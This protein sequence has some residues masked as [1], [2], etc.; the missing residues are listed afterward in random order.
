MPE[1]IVF[2]I[3]DKKECFLDQKIEVSKTS[4]NSK[5]FN[6]NFFPWFCQKSS[7]LPCVNVKQIMQQ[8]IYGILQIEKKAF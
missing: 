1:K 4:K 6:S 7:F 8:K 3:R 2:N 5:F